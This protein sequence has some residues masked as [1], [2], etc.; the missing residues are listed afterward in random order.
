MNSK[1]L[2][3][4]LAVSLVVPASASAHVTIKPG[5]LPA[6]GYARIDVRVPNESDKASTQKVEVQMPDG[7][8]GVLYAPV[9]GW[10]VDVKTSKLDEP[11]ETDDGGITEQVSTITWTAD[12]ADSEIAPGQ[13]QDFG[14][15]VKIPD[16]P[17]E[18]LTFPAIQ[19]YS[20]GEVVRWIGEEDSETPAPTLAVGDE[21]AEDHAAM[22]TG[23]AEAGDEEGPAMAPGSGDHTGGFLA[24]VALALAAVALALSVINRM[25]RS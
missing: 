1:P 16:T 5:E 20:D 24:I 17:G 2:L 9:P 22:D 7:F 23:T 8:A 3:A 19:T 4:V 13:F 6:G 11:I 10:T 14:L 12:D 25:G 15:S 18:T 21:E